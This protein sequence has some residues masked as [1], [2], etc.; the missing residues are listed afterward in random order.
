[1]C[2]LRTTTYWGCESTVLRESIESRGIQCFN[3]LYKEN[4]RFFPARETGN[5]KID[6][7]EATT[8]T[9]SSASDSDYDISLR[10]P[11]K[12]YTEAS[13]DNYHQTQKAMQSIKSAGVRR[14][15]SRSTGSSCNPVELISDQTNENSS[16]EMAACLLSRK[17]RSRGH[18]QELREELL[19]SPQID[20]N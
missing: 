13:S 2:I 7:A 8:F 9:S 20:R 4:F 16:Q 6:M 19:Q 3:V 14:C 10:I 1:M 11:L 12:I 5:L 17:R 18:E 15:Q